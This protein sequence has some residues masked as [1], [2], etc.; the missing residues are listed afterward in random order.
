MG[1]GAQIFQLLASEYIDSDEVDF[2]M[3]VLASLGGA[4]LNNLAGAAL[5]D[6]MPVLA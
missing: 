6:H 4:H 5:D 1:T 2:G 3:T